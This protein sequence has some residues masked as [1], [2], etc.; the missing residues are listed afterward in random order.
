MVK[1][2]NYLECPQNFCLNDGQCL[3]MSPSPSPY[4]YTTSALSRLKERAVFAV[5]D[6]RMSWMR[7]V[8]FCRRRNAHLF[9][10]DVDGARL[11]E[12]A[13]EV[14]RAKSSE[15]PRKF[16]TARIKGRKCLVLN[17]PGLEFSYEKCGESDGV[18]ALCLMKKDEVEAAAASR[19]NYTYTCQCRRGLG[20]ENC[21]ATDDQSLDGKTFCNEDQSAE[22]ESRTLPMFIDHAAYGRPFQGPTGSCDEAL[23]ARRKED[24]CVASNTLAAVTYWCQGKK[25]CRF[26]YSMIID[27]FDHRDFFVAEDAGRGFASASAECSKR[28]GFIAFPGSDLHFRAVKVEIGEFAGKADG[29]WV[30]RRLS[31]LKSGRDSFIK[32]DNGNDDEDDPYNGQ[33][34]IISPEFTLKWVACVT[35]EDDKVYLPLCEISFGHTPAT[36]SPSPKRRKDDEENVSPNDM[37]CFEDSRPFVFEYRFHEDQLTQQ[38]VSCPPIHVDQRWGK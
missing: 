9:N 15:G 24:Y 14:A 20:F 13:Q 37:T 8:R 18:S 34:L 7:S 29:F 1:A 30:D 36:L 11:I 32:W 6:L 17:T 16:W 22:L 28:L 21:T 35:P 23:Y 19:P 2:G 5:S 10:P 26:D 27:A 33:C 31:K 3:V 25:R 4:S 12:A 38:A